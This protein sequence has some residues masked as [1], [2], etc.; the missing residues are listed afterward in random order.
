[1]ADRLKKW[2]RDIRKEAPNPIKGELVSIWD[3]VYECTAAAGKQSKWRRLSHAE[4]L[5]KYINSHAYPT[6]FEKWIL[7]LREQSS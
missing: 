7:D 3:T 2:M 6:P 1:M 4:I 5:D